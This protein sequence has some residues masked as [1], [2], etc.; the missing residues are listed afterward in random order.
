[1]K[2]T[3]QGFSLLEL[4][5]V[6]SIIAILVGIVIYGLNSSQ[7]KSRDAKRQ[8]DLR[9]VE[10]ALEL[11]RSKYG[12]YPSGCNASTTNRTSNSWSGEQGTGVECSSG[13]QYIVNLAPEFIPELPRDP[14][15]G[16]GGTDSGY[17]YTT[18]VSG[19]AYKFMA[20]DAVETEVIGQDH[21][22]FRCGNSFPLGIACPSCFSHT[23]PGMCQR[24]PAGS[25]G[26][27]TS[28]VSNIMSACNTVASYNRTYAVSAGFADN[29]RTNNTN[30][31]FPLRGDEFDVEIVRCK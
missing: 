31:N 19:S 1:M 6:L 15:A 14:R 4:L 12:H 16:A 27:Y 28:G 17:V 22:F 26:N 25:S 5:V 8:A 7:A 30:N 11:F 2:N 23:D 10:S 9:M 24:T 13:N 21:E 3:K 20:L 18:N 29:R